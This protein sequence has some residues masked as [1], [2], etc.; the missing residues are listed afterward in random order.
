MGRDPLLTMY[1]AGVVTLLILLIAVIWAGLR[2]I[3]R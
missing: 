2:D 1:G 3:L